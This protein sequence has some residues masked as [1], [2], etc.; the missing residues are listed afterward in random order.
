MDPWGN[1]MYFAPNDM[2]FDPMAT[3]SQLLNMKP[4][5]DI[6]YNSLIHKSSMVHTYIRF[7]Q[8]C[9]SLQQGIVEMSMFI[10]NWK[11]IH[12]ISWIFNL[13]DL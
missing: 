13:I 6:N 9:K 11:I 5:V 1:E 3:N 2:K 7:H 8:D 10:P 4:I 12:E